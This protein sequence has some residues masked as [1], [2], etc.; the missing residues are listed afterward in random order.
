MVSCQEKI[1]IDGVEISPGDIVI[2]EFDGVLIVPRE[3]AETVLLKSEEIAG[4][5]L[6]V[7][8]DMRNGFS[9]LEGL[10]RHGHI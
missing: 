3:H 5:E 4:I 8:T 2:A 1:K 6:L 7:R 10:A 9:P